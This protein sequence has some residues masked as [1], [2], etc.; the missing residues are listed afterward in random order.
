M[1]I[2]YVLRLHQNKYYIGRTKNYLNRIEQHLAGTGSEWTKK[3]KPIEV[4]ETVNQQLNFTELAITLQYMKEHGI[5]NVRGAIYSSINLS[6][7][8]KQEIQQH[9]RSEYDLC[10]KCGE[11]S[12]FV[13][14]CTCTYKSK[15]F[16]QI[17]KKWFCCF[18]ENSEY[19]LIQDDE[20]TIQFGKYKGHTYKEVLEK[21]KKYCEWVKNTQTSQ[22][23]FNRFK[24]WLNFYT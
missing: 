4:V 22:P 16:S 19:S 14:E 2:I 15:T 24:Q 21:D 12:H 20:N 7:V 13:K 5:E 10:L 23:E 11:S 6:S 1:P 17:L 8:Q 3:Y 18:K 9:I